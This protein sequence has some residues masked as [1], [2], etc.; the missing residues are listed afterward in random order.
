MILM[1]LIM[2]DVVRVRDVM[3]VLCAVCVAPAETLPYNTSPLSPASPPQIWKAMWKPVFPL[4]VQCSVP[5]NLSRCRLCKK[6]GWCVLL[7]KYYMDVY[8]WHVWHQTLKS[9]RIIES[10][11]ERVN[12]VCLIL[13]SWCWV[14]KTSSPSQT[15]SSKL[16]RYHNLY[17][18]NSLRD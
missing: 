4:I 14:V 7:L 8:V 18:K 13:M 11:P 1:L 2:S 10:S 12:C 16:L 6:L 9:S 5:S 15:M 17:K 3:L